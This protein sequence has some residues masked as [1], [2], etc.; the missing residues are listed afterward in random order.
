MQC[1][2]RKGFS[3]QQCPLAMLEKWKS[4]VDNKRTFG[5]LLTNLSKAF[6]CLPHDLLLAKLNVYGFSL[7]TLRLVQ[8]YLAKRK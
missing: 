1:D 2:F 5:A 6:D 3:A 4:A 7:P 8:S